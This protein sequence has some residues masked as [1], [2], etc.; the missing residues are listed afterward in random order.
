ME[1]YGK[2][3]IKTSMYNHDDS[4]SKLAGGAGYTGSQVAPLY[5]AH[6]PPPLNAEFEEMM[7]EIRK[8]TRER[9]QAAK[10]VGAVQRGRVA[11]LAVKL[12]RGESAT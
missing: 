4:D 8:S 6:G 3:L 2:S 11:R 5:S 10:L 7:S 12:M 1:S 9:D